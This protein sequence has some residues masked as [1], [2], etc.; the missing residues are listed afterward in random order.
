LEDFRKNIQISNFIKILQVGGRVVLWGLTDGHAWWS[1]LSL[2][3]ILRRC[4]KIFKLQKLI[5]IRV[6]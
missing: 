5:I 4:L 2:F 6:L 1:Q 3:A